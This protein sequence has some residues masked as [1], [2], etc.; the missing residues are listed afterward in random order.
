MNTFIRMLREPVPPRTSYAASVRELR[1]LATLFDA[2]ATS[3]ALANGAVELNP[4]AALPLRTLHTTGFV[5]LKLGVAFATMPAAVTLH[6]Y[7][8]RT[9]RVCLIAFAYALIASNIPGIIS[10]LIPFLLTH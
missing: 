7:L 8:P 5:P 3:I 1:I 6:R 10:V 2:V 4:L 9:T